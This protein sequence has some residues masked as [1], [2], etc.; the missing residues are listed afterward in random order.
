MG[1]FMPSDFEQ[2][3]KTQTIV[4][5]SIGGSETNVAIGISRLGRK[6]G[7]FSLLGKDPFGD[8]ILYRLRAEGVDTSA[9]RQ[10]DGR[11]GL[12]LK[13]KS[14]TGDPRVFYYRENSAATHMNPEDLPIE[15]IKTSRILH[16]TGITPH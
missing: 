5:K 2:K 11:T 8:E 1:L 12:M 9:V 3:L 14:L 10:T 4:T 15:L 13:E 6:S 16:I 7:W